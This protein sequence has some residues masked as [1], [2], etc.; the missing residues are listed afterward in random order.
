MSGTITFD[1]H[2]TLVECDPWFQIEIRTLVSDVLRYWNDLG[3]IDVPADLLPSADAEYRKLRLAIHG[4]GHELPADRAVRMI[5]ER[6]GYPLPWDAIDIAL[7]SIM[8]AAMETATPVE[9]AQAA[10]NRLA[11]EGVR[12]G[13]VSSAVHH[14]FLI[15]SLDRFDMADAFDQVI[16]SASCG[17]YKSRPE[18]YWSALDQLGADSSHALHIGDSLRFDVGGASQ[19]GMRTA[20]YQRPDARDT[21]TPERMPDLIVPSLVN[22][23]PLLLSTLERS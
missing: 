10:V 2:N 12:L 17:F 3:E 4:H 14:D 13:V 19:A 21:P 22:A 7:D 23:A 20:W 16:T 1:F 18:I 6:I 8:R 11:N 15:W 9:G 5:L